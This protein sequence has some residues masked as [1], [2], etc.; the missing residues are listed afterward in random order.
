MPQLLPFTPSNLNSHFRPVITVPGITVTVLL[1][2]VVAV[3]VFP[4][5]LL[6]LDKRHFNLIE[7]AD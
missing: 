7:K 2:A 5:Y 4:A 6:P 3:H 1:A